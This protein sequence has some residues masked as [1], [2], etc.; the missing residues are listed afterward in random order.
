[1]FTIAD[2]FQQVPQVNWVQGYPSVIDEKNRVMH[3]RSHR[4]SKYFFYLKEYHN[5]EFIQQESTYWRRGLWQKAGAYISQNYKYAGDFE[6]WMR[7]FRFDNLFSTN[8]LI[9]GF[10]M[11]SNGQMSVVHYASY[12]KEADQIIESEISGQKLKSLVKSIESYRKYD[13]KFPWL[14]YFF[15]KYN[16]LP[17]DKHHITFD[18]KL[19]KFTL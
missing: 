12:L 7:F 9:G 2:I 6:L 5:G 8:A 11:R 4:S 3:M 16:P 15:R 18:F 10:R 1:L 19:Q 17:K 13:Q 14:R